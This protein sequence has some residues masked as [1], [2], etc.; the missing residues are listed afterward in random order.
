MEKVETGLEQTFWR[1]KLEDERALYYLAVGKFDEAVFSLKRNRDVF[2]QYEAATGVSV[3]YR[4]LRSGLYLAL[5]YALRG[6][7]RPNLWSPLFLAAKGD[8]H[9]DLLHAR[10]LTYALTA[11][12][13]AAGHYATLQ[14]QAYLLNSVLAA[15]PQEAVVWV[16]RSFAAPFA[17]QEAESRAYSAAAQLRSGDP[18]RALDAVERARVALKPLQHPGERG[19]LGLRARLYSLELR[20]FI[21]LGEVEATAT[22]L[23]TFL[24]NP[25][26]DAYATTL[27]RD[28]GEAA[29]QH[30]GEGARRH[31][32]F[33]LFGD[34]LSDESVR[35]ADALV[36]GWQT[37]EVREQLRLSAVV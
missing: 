8:R 30:L 25:D 27:L 19:D 35:F 24:H 7:G 6:S 36:L 21:A 15:D 31:P 5:A 16:E 34:V 26:L 1:A 18:E 20:A 17:Q 22:V 10:Q 2:T 37:P 13:E 11:Q 9:P 3:S 33:D 28:V 32:G 23:K 12:V 14:R 29:E 4:V